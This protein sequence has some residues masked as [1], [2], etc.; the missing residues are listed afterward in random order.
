MKKNP[1]N[2]GLGSGHIGTAITLERCCYNGNYP[3][4]VGRREAE[5]CQFFPDFPI[6]KMST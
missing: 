3:A 1:E 5:P 2:F 4:R 6:F